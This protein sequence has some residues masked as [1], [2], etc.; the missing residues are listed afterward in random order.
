[1]S[2]HAKISATTG[3]QRQN[4]FL[5]LFETDELFEKVINSKSNQIHFAASSLRSASDIYKKGG[6]VTMIYR[7]QVYALKFDDKRVISDE[8][9]LLPNFHDS[10]PLKDTDQGAIFRAYGHIHGKGKYVRTLPAQNLG[11]KVYRDKLEMG[12]RNFVKAL[13]AKELN[14]DP[15]LFAGY[16][17]IISFIDDF[18]AMKGKKDYRLT[19]NYIATLKRRCATRVMLL[20][21]P[22]LEE[23]VEYIKKKFSNF[24]ENGF[25]KGVS[26]K[27]G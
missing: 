25:Y 26:F 14:L 2:A 11:K 23:F 27:R 1:M 8:K 13:F 21:T 18:C 6:H 17:E 19:P 22:E 15:S 4:L 5:T 12:I 9:I 3:L 20:K 16:K 7:D 24:D 10:E